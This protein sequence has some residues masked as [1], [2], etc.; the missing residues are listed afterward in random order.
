[1]PVDWLAWANRSTCAYSGLERRVKTDEG[2][3]QTILESDSLVRAVLSGSRDP[4]GPSQAR[5]RRLSQD[6]RFSYQIEL[7]RDKQSFHRNVSSGQLAENLV[8]LLRDHFRQALLCC[9]SNDYQILISKKGAWTC[10]TKP[11]SLDAT[12]D[13]AAGGHNRRKQYLVQEGR[14]VAWM[15]ELG[16]MKRDGSVIKQQYHKFRQINRYLEFIDDCLSA[17]PEG[18]PWRIVDFGCGKA[19]LSFALYDWLVKDKAKAVEIVGLDLKAEVV[20]ASSRL[21]TRLGYAGLRFERGDIASWQGSDGADMVICLHACDTATDAALARAVAWRSP[22]ILAVP[23][24]QKELIQKIQ[25]PSLAPLLGYG[26]LRERFGSMATDVLRALALEVM[27]YKTQILEFIETEHTPKNALI[28]AIRNP[29]FDE[30]G[31]RTAARRYLDFKRS[32]AVEPWLERALGA[33]F[34]ARL[35]GV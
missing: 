24:C 34:V 15:Q 12:V 26:L 11:P 27:G 20:K 28:R 9:Q 1:M 33:D 10:L 25:H 19:S 29:A 7:I 16:I 13:E 5:V 14:P 17:L 3:I 21:A 2:S 31:Q 30:S 6:G 8:S 4:A 18:R 22:V 35:E 23:C 32:L